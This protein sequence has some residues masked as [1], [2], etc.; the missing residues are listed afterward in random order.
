MSFSNF[1]VSVWCMRL[2]RY[3]ISTK[4]GRLL[5]SFMHKFRRNSSLILTLFGFFSFHV[6]LNREHT[7]GKSHRRSGIFLLGWGVSPFSRNCN[8]FVI[9][10]F[11]DKQNFFP[12]MSVFSASMKEGAVSAFTWSA[13]EIKSLCF[14]GLC[15]LLSYGYDTEV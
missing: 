5:R 9:A 15:Y 14:H 11:S 7:V 13:Y 8:D 12:R 6:K 1:N 10:C 4:C 2:A 3:K